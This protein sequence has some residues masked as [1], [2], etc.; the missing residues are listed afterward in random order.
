MLQTFGLK[1]VAH[2]SGQLLCEC[3]LVLEGIQLMKII[4]GLKETLV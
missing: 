3:V 1:E 2:G 4:K